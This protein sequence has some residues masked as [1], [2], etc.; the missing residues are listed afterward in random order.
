MRIWLEDIPGVVGPCHQHEDSVPRA[1]FSS[2]VFVSSLIRHVVARS[3]VQDR[4]H[5]DGYAHGTREP[6]T[7]SSF[8]EHVSTLYPRKLEAASAF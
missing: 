6:K 5:C 1:G 4:Q 7:S 8:S 2:F 3:V